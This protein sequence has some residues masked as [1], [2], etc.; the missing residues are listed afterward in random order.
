MKK[1]NWLAASLA[2]VMAVGLAPDTS[3]FFANA[4]DVSS[5]ALPAMT[6]STW[7][8]FCWGDAGGACTV[9]KSVVTEHAK[10][11]GKALKVTKTVTESNA[12]SFACVYYNDFGSAMTNATDDITGVSFW[13][14]NTASVEGGFGFKF[15]G[16]EQG[17]V[18]CVSEGSAEALTSRNLDY[19][20]YRQYFV[21][22]PAVTDL[23]TT[24]QMEIFIW[25]TA[26]TEVYLSSF[27]A[28]YDAA[29]GE[30][31]N[32][33]AFPEIADG[34][35]TSFAWGDNGAA[36]TVEKE[37][38]TDN[39]KS[40]KALKMKKTVTTAGNT[41]AAVYYQNFGATVLALSDKAEGVSFW[42]YNT[43][44]VSGGLGFKF[45]DVE[46]GEI[47]CYAE[48]SNEALTSRN[49][50]YTG[51]RRYFVAFPE[52][53]EL[54]NTNE[55][56]IF[57]WGEANAE[58][59][60]SGFK[61]YAASTEDGGNE[62]EDNGEVT[63]PQMPDMGEYSYLISGF[64][65]QEEVDL[66]GISGQTG[67]VFNAALDTQ[68]VKTGTGSLRYTWNNE[69]Y[70][71]GWT[72]I[73]INVAELF[74]ANAG[75]ELTGLTFELYNQVAQK[76]GSVGFWVKLTEADG[77]EYE[78]DPSKLP[79]GT[80]LDF[81]G[82]RTMYIPFDSASPDRLQSYTTDENDQFDVDQLAYI[83]IGIWSNIADV[84]N[85]DYS[86]DDL[87]LTSKTAITSQGSN[88]GDNNGGDTSNE[89]TKKKSC[90]SS[91]SLLSMGAVMLAA[92]AFVLRRK[93]N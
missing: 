55:F 78:V 9:E 71:F 42:V 49:L 16:V 51:Y 52:S 39:A 32:E 90:S 66:W 73:Y 54:A 84:V 89:E 6:E 72:E 63:P 41:F 4:E 70:T 62:G 45:G 25:G 53:V 11:G 38:V 76:A 82:W 29:E 87:K 68:N 13:A 43:A 28:Y 74:E 75:A 15:N 81:T 77:S 86:I 59:Y 17:N 12:N 79:Y 65:T 19:E 5:A 10:D 24:N 7:S 33:N 8:Q 26:N 31:K 18:T 21:P 93:E 3:A 22:I 36:A 48:D 20:G 58:I 50:D 35:F 88:N 44:S 61:V 14:Y 34:T 69:L 92:C 85:V 67:T 80:A 30:T 40:G 60:L 47:T 64:D 83:K 1:K 57:I 56:Q 2:F 27:A 23:K 91:I 46:Q 37:V